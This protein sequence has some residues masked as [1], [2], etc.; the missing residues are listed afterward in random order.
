MIEKV[1]YLIEW[2]RVDEAPPVGRL[3]KRKAAKA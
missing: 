1:K 2:E 3:A